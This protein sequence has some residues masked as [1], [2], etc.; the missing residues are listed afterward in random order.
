MPDTESDT[1]IFQIFE[2]GDVALQSGAVLP[3]ATLAYKTLGRLNAAGDNAVLMMRMRCDFAPHTC[4][5]KN[6][7]FEF[8]HFHLL[9]SS[10]CAVRHDTT[11]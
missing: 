6:H 10:R 3:A 1:Q 7:F 5:G 11:C 4:R 2:L 9:A 8:V